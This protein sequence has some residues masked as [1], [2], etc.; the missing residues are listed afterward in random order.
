[1][2]GALMGLVH[3]AVENIYA[4]AWRAGIL[5]VDGDDPLSRVLAYLLRKSGEPSSMSLAR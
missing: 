3:V 5:V 1:M 2:E 4:A